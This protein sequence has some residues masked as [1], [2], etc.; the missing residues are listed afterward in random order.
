MRQTLT[1]GSDRWFDL[2]RAEKIEEETW[3]DGRNRRSKATGS[4]WEHETLYRT[5]ASG[6]WVL[7]AWSQWQGSS[8][9]WTEIE[10]AAA[11]RW[12]ARNGHEPH[13]DCAAEFAALDLDA[14]P[15]AEA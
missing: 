1:D 5:A 10:D 6:R 9:D 3:W 14:A 12:L 4:Q 7:H 13:H 2:E 15:V 11:A 8:D